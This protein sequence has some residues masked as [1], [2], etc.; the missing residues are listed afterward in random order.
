MVKTALITGSSSGIGASCAVDLAR[1]GFKIGMIARRGEKLELVKRLVEEAGG[2]AFYYVGDVCDE[3][4]RA[5]V[6]DMMM[7]KYGRID[8]LVNNA[9]YALAG[10]I[11]D[12]ELGMVREFFE[13]NVFAVVGMVKVVGPVMRGQG[14]GRIINMSSI[15]GKV[16]FP[17]LGMYAASKYSVEAISDALRREYLDWNIKVS[18]IEP[19]SINTEIWEKSGAVLSPYLERVRGSSVFG[20]LY[21]VLEGY[22]DPARVGRKPGPEIVSGAVVHAAVSRRPRL[23]Y[24]M[25]FKTKIDNLVGMLPGW[26]LDRIVKSRLGAR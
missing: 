17:G 22:M 6:V 2:E 12:V 25:P 3:S 21:D 1:A 14:G 8:V 13:L 23:R 10:A 26:V 11:E 7:E 9:G 18:I 5:G 16:A 19:G 20:K 15:S 4:A 24:R